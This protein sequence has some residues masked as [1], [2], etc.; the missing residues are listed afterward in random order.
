MGGQNQIKQKTAAGSFAIGVTGR[1]T[2]SAT[3]HAATTRLSAY[4][5]H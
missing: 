1:L 3:N 5:Y 4:G 2:F